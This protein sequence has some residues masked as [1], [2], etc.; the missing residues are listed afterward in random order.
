[1]AASQSM[2]A[3]AKVLKRVYERKGFWRGLSN[4]WFIKAAARLPH[5]G[6]RV[7]RS[8]WCECSYFHVV[9]IV[10]GVRSLHQNSPMP[11]VCLQSGDHYGS[12][13]LIRKSW[14]EYALQDE[15]GTLGGRS[16]PN[17]AGRRRGRHDA[18]PSLAVNK[19]FA[20]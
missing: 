16:T 19:G 11:S 7:T 13:E 9:F 6:W 15:R 5:R 17:C 4:R 14:T 8:A 10:S 1:M 12:M 3:S 18:P 2:T 20:T